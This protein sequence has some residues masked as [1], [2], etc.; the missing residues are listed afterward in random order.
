MVFVYMLLLLVISQDNKRSLWQHSH[1]N[2]F[3][4]SKIMAAQRSVPVA[5]V[6]V[7]ANKK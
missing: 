3:R 1:T 4:D 6:L 2:N 7:S 5:R